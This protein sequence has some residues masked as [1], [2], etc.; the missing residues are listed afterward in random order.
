MLMCHSKRATIINAILKDFRY[1]EFE[2]YIYFNKFG[3]KIDAFNPNMFFPIIYISAQ[4][5]LK[6]TKMD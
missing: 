6:W 1:Y 4:N 3:Y 5:R 2:I